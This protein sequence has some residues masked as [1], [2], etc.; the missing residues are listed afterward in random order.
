M[1]IIEDYNQLSISSLQS[2]RL[3][4]QGRP[5]LSHWSR[6]RRGILINKT[7]I[8]DIIDQE[9][10]S[11]F[12]AIDCAGWY[13]ANHQRK[14]TAIELHDL[15]LQFWNNVHYEYDYLTWHPTYLPNI[16]V[17]AYYSSYFKY[18]DLDDFLTFC[19]IWSE[20]H[21]KIIIGL[22]PT[23]IKFNYLKWELLDLV[24]D[25]LPNAQFRILDKQNFNLLF[26]IEQ[27]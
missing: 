15:S 17:L 8:I 18:C 12:V 24:R 3:Y 26:T 1:K 14:C 19:N 4:L 27:K 23:K 10:F 21:S 13:F 16:T 6:K 5:L 11:D 22:D 25:Q 20:K 2:M 9:I 7:P